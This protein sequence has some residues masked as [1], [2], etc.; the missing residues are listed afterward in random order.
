MA[1]ELVTL[2]KYRDLP[3]AL[4]V[5]SK[6]EFYAQTCF[7]ADENIVRLNWFLSNAVGGMRLQ[8][9]VTNREAAVSLL[10]EDIPADFTVDEVGEEYQQ[11][12]CPTCH[13]RDVTF[14][15]IFKGIAL[16]ALWLVSLPVWIPK[17]SWHCEKCGHNWKAKY[18]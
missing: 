11:P 18:D 1:E 10:T 2:W 17:R 8:V 3:E 14:R 5:Q 15:P 7:L 6:L 16:L 4:V 12:E 9:E 13:S